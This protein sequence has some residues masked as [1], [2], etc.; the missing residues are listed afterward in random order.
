MSPMVSNIF[1]P[2]KV[3]WSLA[4]TKA[5][6]T[7]EG[8]KPSQGYHTLLCYKNAFVLKKF[9]FVTRIDDCIV[10]KNYNLFHQL[11]FIIWH[12]GQ[13]NAKLTLPDVTTKPAWYIVFPT[14]LDECTLHSLHELYTCDDLVLVCS[15][16]KVVSSVKHL[17]EVVPLLEIEDYS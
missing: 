14:L 1:L 8:I 4:A 7:L 9:L 6:V 12:Y 11:N 16:V 15:L 2:W 5:S 17:I 10:S 3:R 13:I